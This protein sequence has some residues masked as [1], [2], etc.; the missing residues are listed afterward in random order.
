MDGCFI[1]AL[2][3]QGWSALSAIPGRLGHAKKLPDAAK[4]GGDVGWVKTSHG[5][6]PNDMELPVSTYPVK[7]R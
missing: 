6:T 4:E 3:R 7:R 1:R 5:Q 2:H